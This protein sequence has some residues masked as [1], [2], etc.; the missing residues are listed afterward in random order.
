MKDY[1]KD[2][3]EKSKMHWETDVSKSV[4]PKPDKKNQLDNFEA[5]GPKEWPRTH[6]KVNDCDY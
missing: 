2:A 3:M 6:V 5:K 4:F 1:R